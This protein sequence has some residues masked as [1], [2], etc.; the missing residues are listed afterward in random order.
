MKAR[1]GFSVL[2]TTIMTLTLSAQPWMRSPYLKVSK[3]EANFT[4]MQQ[5]FGSWWGDK[6]Y[7]KGKG[8]KQF[9]RWEYIMA[10]VCYPDGQLPSASRFIDAYNYAVKAA[11]EEKESDATANWIPLGIT[12]WTN[13]NSGYNPGNGRVNFIAEHPTDSNILY[14]ATPSGGVWQ[15]TDGGVNWT[16]TFD[17][18]LRLGTSCVAIHPT[19]PNIVFVGTGDK[20]GWDTEAFGILKSENSGATWGNG[21]LNSGVSFTNINKILINPQNPNSMLV[22]TPSNIFKSLNG[23]I[24]WSS[25]YSGSDIRNMVYKPGDTTTIY[26]GGDIFL[27][28][29][30]GGNT[31][32]PNTSVPN[33][34]CRIE[35]A[36]T[37]ANPAYVYILAS[38]SQNSF[39]GVYRSTNSGS[40]FLQMSSSPNILGYSETGDDDAGQAWY[41]LAI[42]VSPVDADQ[43][44][45][46]GVNVWR[47]S[48][49]GANWNILTHWVYGG[50]YGYSHADIH[51]LAFFGTRLYCGSDGGAFVSHDFGDTWNDISSGLEITQ[52][53]AFSNSKADDYFVVAGAQDNGSNMYD[54]GSWTHVFG[55]DGFEALTDYNN[56]DIYYASYQN[57]GILRTTDGG[58]NF[59]YINTTGQDG[60]WLTPLAM[61]PQSSSVI[62]MAL[63]DLFQS[64][65]GGDNWD[66]LT[67]GLTSGG[68]IDELAIA[69]TGINDIYF[70]NS[71]TLYY[72]HNG[73]TSWTSTN[74]VGSFFITGIAVSHAD[75]NKLWIT[76]SSSSGDRVFKSENGGVSWSNVTGALSGLG[77]NCIIEDPNS[78]EG[79]YVGS[80]IGVFY[81]DT[82]MSAWLNFDTGLPKVIVRELEINAT[83]SKLRGATYGRGLWETHLYNSTGIDNGNKTVVEMFPNPCSDFISITTIEGQAPEII[84]VFDVSGRF[85]SE[86]TVTSNPA[87]LDV[88]SLPTG[89][90]YLRLESDNQVLDV[91]KIMVLK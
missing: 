75:A 33:D 3:S 48:D 80:N 70:S 9:K 18:Q 73:G 36:V 2:L 63:E 76:A 51:Y 29:T 67:N 57:G 86:E 35:I 20:D 90:Y 69:P 71:S 30:D 42:A 54:N 81:T 5:A 52:F 53:Y 43:V 46:G 91:Q 27:K 6:P 28:S 62:F 87:M 59:D 49:G 4:D 60:S 1:V 84:R 19:N 25:V 31:F 55:A 74:P 32:I 22:C 65:D 45:V 44:F 8:F 56:K 7:E 82:T 47:S 50:G 16:T 72:S 83:G 37:P 21:G 38:N 24:N 14:V 66:N 40:S 64:N 88:R 12:T 11:E 10:P 34:T 23:G 68:K 77:L 41:D 89:N 26:C 39:G 79:L 13:G 85:I 15:T 78:P 17:D 61:S 58:N